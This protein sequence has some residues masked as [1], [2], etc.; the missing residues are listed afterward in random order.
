MRNLKGKLRLRTLI[1]LC[2]SLELTQQRKSQAG[3]NLNTIT[4]QQWEM[5]NEYAPTQQQPAPAAS[6]LRLELAEESHL[7]NTDDESDA[8]D[9][10]STNSCEPKS[11]SLRKALTLDSD[12]QTSDTDNDFDKENAALFPSL[13]KYRKGKKLSKHGYVSAFVLF[14]NYQN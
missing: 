9:K 1:H 6:N 12:N 10:R 13:D 4:N 14:C 7:L 5:L 3:N 8:A 2:L 11:K